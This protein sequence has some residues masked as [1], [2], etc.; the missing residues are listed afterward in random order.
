MFCEICEKIFDNTT[1]LPRTYL[2][3]QGTPTV[4]VIITNGGNITAM[5]RLNLTLSAEYDQLEQNVIWQ[6]LDSGLLV[7]GR[8][9][10]GTQTMPK[11]TVVIVLNRTL[12]N[13]EVGTA[14][15]LVAYFSVESTCRHL[16]NFIF[17]IWQVS[18]YFV[19]LSS[20]KQTKAN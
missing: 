2:V 5:R 12:S 11:I 1:H 16:E 19:V 14:V 17:H 8:V 15:K 3:A 18:T 10:T 20:S 13:Q 9:L 4:V 6:R 7:N